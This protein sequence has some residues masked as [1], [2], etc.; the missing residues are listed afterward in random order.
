MFATILETILVKHLGKYLDGIKKN[1]DISI[2]N[3]D[4]TI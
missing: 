4:V 1:M 2:I 3:G